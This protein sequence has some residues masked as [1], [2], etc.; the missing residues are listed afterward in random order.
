MKKLF[1]QFL[2]LLALIIILPC[3]DLFKKSNEQNTLLRGLI[4]LDVN[5]NDVYSDIH[6]KGA[7]HL[8]YDKIAAD[9]NYL[10]NISSGWDKKSELVV[11]CTNYQCTASDDVAKKLLALG[12]DNVRVL[13]AGIQTWYQL[14]QKNKTGYPYEGRATMSFLSKPVNTEFQ[15]S[16]IKVIT[17]ELLAYELSKS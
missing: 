11:Y 4:I 2:I 14:A 9:A 1:P 8:P 13:K 12:F 3:C 16:E 15:E 17:P 5:D 6:I 7:L 10:K